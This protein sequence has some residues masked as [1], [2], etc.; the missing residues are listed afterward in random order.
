MSVAPDV[1]VARNSTFWPEYTWIDFAQPPHDC[2]V[3]VCQEPPFTRASTLLIDCVP[4]T[5]VWTHHS[6]TLTPEN[7]AS[8]LPDEVEVLVD[9]LV[10]VV[11][12]ELPWMSFTSSP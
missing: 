7:D 11:V 1:L 4:L 3:R 10:V 6:C 2:F 12:L 9:V 8:K 5:L